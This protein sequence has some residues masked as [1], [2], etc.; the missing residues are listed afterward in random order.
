MS[1]TILEKT[2]Q[3]QLDI[4]NQKI[5]PHNDTTFIKPRMFDSTEP[6]PG[7]VS[8]MSVETKGQVDWINQHMTDEMKASA[9][10]MVSDGSF[11]GVRSVDLFYKTDVANA[12]VVVRYQTEP[13][14]SEL[15]MGRIDV[16]KIS[17]E[18][19]AQMTQENTAKVLPNTE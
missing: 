2:F 17:P 12:F 15:N 16:V 10:T 7:G 8:Y 1:D 5:D 6:D 4:Y 14:M 11:N 18:K 9:P 3:P 19:L 13:E